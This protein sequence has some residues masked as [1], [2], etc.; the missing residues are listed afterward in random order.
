MLA[1]WQENKKSFQFAGSQV[2]NSAILNKFLI[3]EYLYLQPFKIEP[4][5]SLLHYPFL[6]ISPSN[7]L[8]ILWNPWFE[9][10]ENENCTLGCK[11]DHSSWFSTA[12]RPH[13]ALASRSAQH[14]LWNFLNVITVCFQ[15]NMLVHPHPQACNIVRMFFL[16]PYILH[17]TDPFPQTNHHTCPHCL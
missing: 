5:V 6:N 13:I 12:A 3:L 9:R 1:S 2:K 15:N 8:K 11:T 16:A 17:M 14:S 4:L 7:L 10:E